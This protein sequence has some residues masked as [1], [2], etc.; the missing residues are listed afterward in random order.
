YYYYYYYYYVRL[1]EVRTDRTFYEGE[2]TTNVQFGLRTD[3]TPTHHHTVFLDIGATR[4]GS[5]VEDSPLVDKANQTS[6][7]LGYVYRF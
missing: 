5:T 3:F 4:F 7:A 6:L 1:S 2:A